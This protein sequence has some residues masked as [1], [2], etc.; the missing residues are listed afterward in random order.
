MN[1]ES[2]GKGQETQSSEEDEEEQDSVNSIEE[3]KN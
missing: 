3:K 1:Q 2:K